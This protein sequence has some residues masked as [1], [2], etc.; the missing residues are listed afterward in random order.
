MT[1][2]KNISTTVDQRRSQINTFWILALGKA[3]RIAGPPGPGGYH[4]KMNWSQISSSCSPSSSE[5]ETLGNATATWWCAAFHRPNAWNRSCALGHPLARS[6][7]SQA[8]SCLWLFPE[9][10][11]SLFVKALNPSWLPPLSASPHLQR[12]S[13]R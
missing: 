10:F 1:P 4:T 2:S 13:P 7:A 8:V 3:C 11:L 9:V 12:A 6:Q 5:P